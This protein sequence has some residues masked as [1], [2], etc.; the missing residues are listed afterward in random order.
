[1]K[2]NPVIALFTVFSFFYSSSFAQVGAPAQS[3]APAQA[4][5]FTDSL[6]DRTAFTYDIAEPDI[7]KDIQSILARF[8]QAVSADKEWFIDY[9]NKY[10]SDGQPLPYNERFGITLGE[11]MRIQQLEKTPPR[12]V[13]LSRQNVIVTRENNVIHFKGEGEAI[14]FNYLEI[15]LQQQK[16]IF[17]GDTLLFEGVMNAAQLSP[18][19]LTQGY[20]WRLEKADLKSTLQTNEITARVAELDLGLPA[21]SGRTFLRIKYQDMQSGMTRADLDLTGFVH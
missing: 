3:G 7:S 15:D 2:K 1:M 12:M 13:T 9:R 14:I 19:H 8:S 10:A 6:F 21:E 17:A 18:F 16:I 4:F 5:Q 20:M 11:Y